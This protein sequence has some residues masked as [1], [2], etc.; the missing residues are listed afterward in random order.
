MLL[1]SLLFIA[2]IGFLAQ[3]TGLCMVRGVKEAISGKPVFLISILLSG[4]LMW[5]AIG[6][7]HFLGQPVTYATQFPTLMSALGGLIFGFGAAFNGGCGVS[8]ISRFARG[9]VMMA[10]TILGWLASWLLFSELLVGSAGKQYQLSAVGHMGTLITLS[11]ILLIVAFKSDAST[12]T[13][14]LSML[15]IGAMAGLVFIYEPH[16]T[17]S[18]LL[19]SIGVSVWNG[20]DDSWPRVERFY[21]FVGLVLGMVIASVITKSF[22]FELASVMRLFKHFMAGMLMGVGAVMAG[23][24]NDSQL[25]VALPALSLAGLVATLCIVIGIYIGVTVQRRHS[26]TTL[27][28][29]E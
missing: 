1:L 12:R 26:G 24:G 16:W 22:K 8:T 23:G 19:K 13:L 29:D 15:G 9:Q 5:L 2:V 10:A 25:L 21:L 6:A 18:G 28:I 7:A 14:W 4:S 27:N 17:P 11:V 3:T 20:H